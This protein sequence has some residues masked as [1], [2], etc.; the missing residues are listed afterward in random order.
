MESDESID[1]IDSVAV[2]AYGSVVAKE[3]H[4]NPCEH[5]EEGENVDPPRFHSFIN[6]FNWSLPSLLNRTKGQLKFPARGEELALERVVEVVVHAKQQIRIV[7]Q[8]VSVADVP[9]M[10][11]LNLKYLNVP[12]SDI[13]PYFSSK[14]KKYLYENV[15]PLFTILK[16]FQ[17]A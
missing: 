5:F 1:F 17:A 4:E 7:T 12:K 2:S 16:R 15:L 13:F 14:S 3:E 9:A 8:T 6:F 11:W 10:K